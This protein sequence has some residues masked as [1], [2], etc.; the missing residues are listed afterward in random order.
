MA[1]SSATRPQPPSLDEMRKLYPE[2]RDVNTEHERNMSGPEKMALAIARRVGTPGFFTLV[3][4]WTVG[5][6]Y[7]NL[8][9]PHALRFDAPR[10]F[11]FW[12][13]LSNALQIFL[14]P[15]L[16][17]ASNLQARHAERRADIQYQINERA[18]LEL[19]VVLQHL[20]F[21][22]GVLAAILRKV[23]GECADAQVL[24][25]TGAE[26]IDQQRATIES[27]SARLSDAHHSAGASFNGTG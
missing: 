6:A 27:L 11:E 24:A 19:E 7:W 10:A 17:V 12:I 14:M 13:F 23:D 25:R 1:S 26:V 15:L 5:W 8:T 16:L 22:N 3:V 21:Q 20:E 9:A 18:Q 2:L 4:V